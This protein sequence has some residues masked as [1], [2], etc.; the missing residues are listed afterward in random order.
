MSVEF[1]QHPYRMAI[2][3][4]LPQEDQ[5]TNKGQRKVWVNTSKKIELIL[6]DQSP[7]GQIWES[8]RFQGKNVKDLKVEFKEHFDRF[9]EDWCERLF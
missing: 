1:R 5:N 7:A 8:L 2:L 4:G 9:D 3:L 6:Y